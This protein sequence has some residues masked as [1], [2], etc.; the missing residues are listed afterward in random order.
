[1][2]RGD[3]PHEAA[4]AGCMKKLD[5][6]STAL[7]DTRTELQT[8]HVQNQEIRTD[9]LQLRTELMEIKRKVRSGT[10]SGCVWLMQNRKRLK[11]VHISNK[12]DVC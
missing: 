4:P 8:V 3:Q 11:I 6:I 10:A 12:T 2:T 9:N 5:A 7:H 1:M